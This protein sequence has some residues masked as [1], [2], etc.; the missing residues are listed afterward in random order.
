VL[1]KV[2]SVHL[3]KL[4]AP[5][6]E[7]ED[8]M[9][10]YL[11]EATLWIAICLDLDRS[12]LTRR[13]VQVGGNLNIANAEVLGSGLREGWFENNA[14]S[15]A[16]VV[17]DGQVDRAVDARVLHVQLNGEEAGERDLCAVGLDSVESP[18]WEVDNSIF[19]EA[20]RRW[21]YEVEMG[22]R[23]EREKKRESQGSGDHFAIDFTGIDVC[24]V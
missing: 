2:T 23:G 18:A 15:R 17:A 22:E 8:V 13:Q 10:T 1:T 16:W 12:I 6:H 14:V 24:S 20:T 7:I 9:E 3:S 5:Y 4:S 11:V 19:T 21:P